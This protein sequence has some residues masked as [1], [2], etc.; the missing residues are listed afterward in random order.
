M[1]PYVWMLV[2]YS[3]LLDL[4]DMYDYLYLLVIDYYLRMSAWYAWDETVLLCVVGQQT[5]E[6]TSLILQVR[7]RFSFM[8]LAQGGQS[9]D[10]GP[11]CMHC[12]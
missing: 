8:L 6:R 3:D 11:V 1:C 4:V 2:Y 10:V 5:Q 9:F 12:I 7:E